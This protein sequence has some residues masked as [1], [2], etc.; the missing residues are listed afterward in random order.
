MPEN[1]QDVVN[2]EL[3]EF[4]RYPGDGLPNEPIGAPLPVGDPQSGVHNPKKAG[5]RKALLAPL[6]AMGAQLEEATEQAA[7]AREWAQSDDPISPEAGGD[8]E[9]DRSAKFWAEIRAAGFEPRGEYDPGTTYLKA[10]VVRSGDGVWLSMQDDNTGN[11]PSDSSVWWMLLLDESVT[12]QGVLDRFFLSDLAEDYSLSEAA[13]SRRN[14][15]A[16]INGHLLGLEFSNNLSD[17]DHDVDIS[18]GTA[19]SD[20]ADPVLIR[21]E[22]ALTKRLDATFAEGGD[23]GGFASGESLPTSGTVHVWAIAKE[24]GTSDVF[25]NNHGSSGL[26]PTLPSGFVYKRRIC[27]LCTDASANL[28]R[29]IQ[30]GNEFTFYQRRPDVLVGTAPTSATLA[31]VSVPAGIPVNVHLNV[32][33]S[34]SAGSNLIVTSPLENDVAP[35]NDLCTVRTTSSTGEQAQNDVSVTTETAQ[36]RYR[37]GGSDVGNLRIN[38]KGYTD[39]R[40]MSQSGGGVASG[41]GARIASGTITY[42]VP[43]NFSTPQEAIDAFTGIVPRPGVKCQILIESG[44]QLPSGTRDPGDGRVATFLCM[45]GDYSFIEIVSEDAVVPVVSGYTGS[46]VRN[47]WAKGIVLNCLIDMGGQGLNGYSAEEGS[48]GRVIANGSGV[49]N[50]GGIGLYSRQNSLIH[51]A[52]ALSVWPGGD[53]SGVNFSGAGTVGL[54]TNHGG[55]AYVRAGNFSGAGE[56]GVYANHSAKVDGQGVNVSNCPIGIHANEGSIVNSR[57]GNAQNCGRAILATQAS[58]VVATNG[59][60]AR[61][62]THSG[63]DGIVAALGGSV[64]DF[65]GGDVRNA[66]SVPMVVGTG[67]RLNARNVNSNR[68]SNNI[69]VENGGT[70]VA[71]GTSFELSQAT[72]AI[73]SAG[74]IFR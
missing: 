17:L 24:D 73:T 40:G 57:G 58:T 34:S 23:S 31:N 43:S 72:N 74:V 32:I 25:A 52:M 3:R 19:A 41:G 61:G 49:I 66:A 26:S 53:G 44:Y 42:R 8:G 18:I 11:G 71:N 21:C 55:L 59:F 2:R 7:H 50:A 46:A 9:T 13:N 29:T 51:A 54:Y 68:P 63:G 47:I 69:R 37:R 20:D 65:E 60:D 1:P 39:L 36:F 10:D 12:A 30:R 6:E 35:S 15:G 48:T 38:T 4:K 67:S 45:G 56:R 62:G 70:A 5:L 33:L 64:I 27:S 16:V 28:I 22:N 14:L